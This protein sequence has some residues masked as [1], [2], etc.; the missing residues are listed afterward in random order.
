[1]NTG[2]KILDRIQKLLRLANNAGSEAEAALAAERARKMMAE[3]EI[4]EAMISLETPTEIAPEPIE[5]G[6]EVTKTKKKVAWHMRIANAVAHSYGGR[7]YWT[8]GRIQMFGRLSAVQA[9]NYTTHYLLREVERIT[10]RDADGTS[11]S[12]RNA[13]RLGCATRIAERITEQ[14]RVAKL[15]KSQPTFTAAEPLDGE[16]LT[17]REDTQE[18]EVNP[19]ALAIVEK[20]QQEVDEEYATFSRRFGRAVN[21]GNYSS[22][23]GYYAGRSAGER[24][25]LGGN[26]RGGLK[27]G[28]GVLR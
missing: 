23:G 15:A 5:K 22:G 25:N 19:L 14:A 8:G 16:G 13:F 18:Q 9:A 11:K 21:V 28:Q 24:A 17:A 10:D 26:A 3:H 12:F 20:N 4:H 6:F 7:A 1:M 27:A 2:N